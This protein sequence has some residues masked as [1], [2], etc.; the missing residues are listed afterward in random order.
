M[1]D[2]IAN[3]LKKAS[4]SIFVQKTNYFMNMK[5]NFMNKAILRMS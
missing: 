1:H 3:S 2:H 4:L 5:K